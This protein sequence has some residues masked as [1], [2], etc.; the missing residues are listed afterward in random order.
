MCM[1]TSIHTLNVEKASDAMS[2]VETSTYL[3]KL[4]KSLS[5]MISLASGSCLIHSLNMTPQF[6]AISEFS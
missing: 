1:Y 3:K 5:S 2:N 4:K 6:N